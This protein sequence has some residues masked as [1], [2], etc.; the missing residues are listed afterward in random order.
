VT[1]D[2]L[3]TGLAADARVAARRVCRARRADARADDGAKRERVADADMP[4][5]DAQIGMTMASR[6]TPSQR[7]HDD[8]ENCN[9]PRVPDDASGRALASSRA[10]TMTIRDA[11]K[12][13]SSRKS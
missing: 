9:R 2:A 6:M 12:E 7:I 13:T 8:E 5:R 10:F 1:C 3:S 4:L 11:V